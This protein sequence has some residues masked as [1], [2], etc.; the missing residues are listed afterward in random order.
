MSA[1]DLPEAPNRG[2][3]V[4]KGI[5]LDVETLV[6]DAIDA[7]EPAVEPDA[8]HD[9]VATGLID[10]TTTSDADVPVVFAG[11]PL[12]ESGVE[13]EIK[14]CAVSHSNGDR[15]TAGRWVMKGRDDGQHD[16]LLDDGS[17]Y[18]LAVYNETDGGARELLA[19]AIIPASLLDE[20]LR[21]RWYSID[22]CEGHLARLG[23][24][25]VLPETTVLEASPTDSPTD[26]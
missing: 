12:V 22:R 13:V 21:G 3:A 15:E 17:M 4:A 19:I 6:V 8:H 25:H 1:D 24:T 5:G 2:L 23:W 16:A 9:A 20:H 10:P 26:E 7:L 14:A 11:V 18:A